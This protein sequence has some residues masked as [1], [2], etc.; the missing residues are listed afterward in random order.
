MANFTVNKAGAKIYSDISKHE[1]LKLP[2]LM[3]DKAK[4]AVYEV[5][6][7]GLLLGEQRE[8]VAT[9]KKSDQEIVVY[10]LPKD[11]QEWGTVR[12]TRIYNV[13]PI[14]KITPPTTITRPKPKNRMRACFV[15]YLSKFLIA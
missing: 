4:G 6:S 3:N 5:L 2:M 9:I 11:L 1:F 7:V 14:F 10:R 8:P 15:F 13:K 12:K